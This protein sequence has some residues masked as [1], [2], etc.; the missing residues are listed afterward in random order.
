MRKKYLSA[1]LFGAL[2]F[3][4]AG[5]FTSCKDYDDDIN[6]LQEQIDG[7]TTK[8]DMEAKLSQMET[9][10]NDAKA[11]AE[12][13]LKVAQEA[14]DADEIAKLEE[15]IKALED[16]AIDVDALKK[17]I[18]DSVDAQMADFREEMKK[19]LAEVEELTGYSL[20]MVTG[21]SFVTSDENYST[22]LDVNYA[23]VEN[24]LIP[25][26]KYDA[27]KQDDEKK[28]IDNKVFASKTSYTFGEGFTGEFTINA[29]DV[30]T[31]VDEMLVKLDPVNSVITSDMLSLIN[32]KGENL[33]D[34]VNITCSAW[35]DNIKGSRAAS[36]TG[37]Y[38]IGVQLKNDVDFEAFD[39]M[40]L[41]AP[42]KHD[43]D[44]CT[45]TGDEPAHGFYMFALAVSDAEK[46]RTV[47]SGYEVSLHVQKEKEAK[48][49]KEQS[50]LSSS[51][52]LTE[53]AIGDKST[54]GDNDD[55][56]FPIVLGED[57]NLEVNSTEG[58]VMA[59]Y[60]IVDI[61]NKS[62]S[63]TDKVAINTLK[64]EGVKNVTTGNTHVL[65]IS[66]SAG[67]AV[68]MKLVTIDYTGV[69]KENVFWVKASTPALMTAKFTMSPAEFVTSPKAWFDEKITASDMQEFKIPAGATHYTLELVAGETYGATVSDDYSEFIVDEPTAL[70]WNEIKDKNS[71]SVLK[72]YKSD[73]KTTATKQSEVA[74]AAFSGTLNLQAM[75]E[76]KA[77]S[78]IIK[79]YNGDNYLGSNSIT[80]TKSLPT[81]MPAGFSAKTNAINNGVMT[82]YPE[83]QS[84]KGVFD[85]NKAFNGWLTDGHLS[86]TIDGITNLAPDKVKAKVISSAAQIT[87]IVTDVIG[88]N[89]SYESVIKYNYGDIKYI[90]TGHGVDSDAKHEVTW[91]TEF[92]TKFGCWPVDCEYF[93]TGTPVVYYRE[94]NVILG[95][96]TKDGEGNVTA[97]ENVIGVKTPYGAYADP[98]DSTD[99]D[100]TTWA[101]YFDGSSTTQNVTIELY[102]TNNGKEVKDEFFTAKFAVVDSNGKEVPAGTSGAK[103][104]MVL[105]PTSTEVVLS[106]DVETK[107]VLK[108]TDEFNKERSVSA[109][110]FTMKKDHK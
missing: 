72:L 32:G 55:N 8:E 20:D 61:N 98:F 84:T 93:W 106:G 60:V 92:A 48:E 52:S 43:P 105:T 102:T 19:L 81:E 78:G 100:W 51:A 58:K 2:L 13:A 80:V 29:K 22:G 68:P 74:Y 15:R 46:S 4:S 49:I 39:K 89:N 23:R 35:S 28:D 83:P 25:G 1:L 26:D 104:A 54:A 90:P 103:N 9:A 73:K 75:R 30:N 27:D 101:K 40:V 42:G 31:V 3:A 24:I 50:K 37:L 76:D 91:G 53:V 5:T 66:G 95:K 41:P 79:F 14:G 21:I 33:N 96:V 44:D 47:T 11:T 17:E 70:T 7:L 110:T 86:L 16:A 10:I 56:C 36:A 67:V 97:F 88:D 63:T 59:S 108:F 107:V 71:K 65:K 57:F 85:L 109:L 45:V 34:Y 82:I 87:E 62:L 94:T 6:N 38:K 64:F 77:Y 12:E 69:V 18:A 99:E